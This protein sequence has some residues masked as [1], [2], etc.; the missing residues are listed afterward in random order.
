MA[1]EAPLSGFCIPD[2]DELFFRPDDCFCFLFPCF[3]I[4]ISSTPS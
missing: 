4:S 2:F 1:E 3:A